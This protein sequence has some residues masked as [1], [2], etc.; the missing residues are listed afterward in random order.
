MR[1]ALEAGTVHQSCAYPQVN[2]RL[3]LSRI[4]A[5]D[6]LACQLWTAPPSEAP[7]RGQQALTRLAARSPSWKTSAGSAR[8]ARGAHWATRGPRSPTLLEPLLGSRLIALIVQHS[9]QPGLR[10]GILRRWRAPARTAIRPGSVP[11]DRAGPP[12][13][14]SAWVGGQRRGAR[15]GRVARQHAPVSA[16]STNP[17]QR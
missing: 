6:G 9:G 15:P 11:L 1:L 16:G 14:P 8:S 3:L 2:S 17:T 7:R 5:Q 10:M 4:V 13:G 12:R